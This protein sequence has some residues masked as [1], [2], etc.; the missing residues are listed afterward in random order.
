MSIIVFEFQAR[1]SGGT[2]YRLTFEVFLPPMAS[3][4]W[5]LSRFF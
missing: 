3:I 5:L 2:T 1:K 4:V